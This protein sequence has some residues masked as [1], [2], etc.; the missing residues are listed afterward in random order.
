MGVGWALERNLIQLP[1]SCRRPVSYLSFHTP[2]PPSL[3]RRP[4]FDFHPFS[5]S[6]LR[7]LQP[8]LARNAPLPRNIPGVNAASVFSVPLGGLQTILPIFHPSPLLSSPPAPL[9]P[10][11]SYS[12]YSDSLSFHSKL[13]PVHRCVSF[14]ARFRMLHRA[15]L[16]AEHGR[17]CTE[18]DCSIFARNNT[19]HSL[20]RAQQTE[21]G[22]PESNIVSHHDSESRIL[23]RMYHC[24]RLRNS[25]GDRT[26][27]LRK[28]TRSWRIN[29]PLLV[30]VFL[31][32]SLLYSYSSE[33]FFTPRSF[34][35]ISSFRIFF[36][37]LLKIE[38]RK[39]FLR[40]Y[41]S[42]F[43]SYIFNR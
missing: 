14:P 28:M 34:R 38:T 5:A 6:C 36:F 15:F 13:V 31:E 29:F 4:T 24:P 42:S 2:P 43:L 22:R 1:A 19:L 27:R 12:S 7:L 39:I 10:F 3:I 21:P 16:F 40:R 32:S 35:S 17:C 18:G 26:F 8:T 41:L 23:S 25:K 33:L 20:N 11:I 9:L 37:L 30:L